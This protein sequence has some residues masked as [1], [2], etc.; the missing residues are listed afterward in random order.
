M[1]GPTAEQFNSGEF[2]TSHLVSL[3]SA[4]AVLRYTPSREVAG[5]G[6]QF[7]RAGQENNEQAAHTLWTEFE[8][9]LEHQLECDEIEHRPEQKVA[10]ARRVGALMYESAVLWRSNS[11][12]ESSTGR[13]TRYARAT[14]RHGLYELSQKEIAVPKI[15]LDALVDTFKA[16]HSMSET[17]EYIDKGRFATYETEPTETA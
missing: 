13:Y 4:A 17:P 3:D 12:S 14:L 6:L 1:R 5:L 8:A 2:I 10:R 9:E 7:N 16:M 11:S 15:M